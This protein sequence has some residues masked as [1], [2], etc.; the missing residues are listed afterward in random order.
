MGACAHRPLRSSWQRL[1]CPRAGLIGLGW[2]EEVAN[3]CVGVVESERPGEVEGVAVAVE[4][5]W[6]VVE[7][8][9]DLAVPAD[10]APRGPQLYVKPDDRWEVNDLRQHNLDLVEEHEKTLREFI[11]ATRPPGP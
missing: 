5:R 2:L 7:V 3:L 6:R 9:D 8:V 11:A 1:L 10:D 4:H